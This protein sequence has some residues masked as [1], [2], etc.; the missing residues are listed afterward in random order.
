MTG[1]LLEKERIAKLPGVVWDNRVEQYR[2]PARFYREL[3]LELKNIGFGNLK[4]FP[5]YILKDEWLEIP[6]RS[7]QEMALR[8]WTLADHKGVI[9]LPT[10]AGKT[11]VAIAAIKE[12]K[13]A[14][15]CL[16]PTRV[17][18]YQWFDSIKRFYKGP[19]GIIGDG[20]YEIH[21]ITVCTYESA[22][23]YISRFGNKFSL[24]VVDETHHF[25]SGL[26]DEILEMSVAPFRIGLTATVPEDSEHIKKLSDIIGPIV[27]NLSIND[28]SGKYLAEYE[29][30]QFFLDL[31]ERERMAYRQEISIFRDYM[32]KNNKLLISGGWSNLM[33]IAYKTEE[34]IR[35]FSSLRRATQIVG[36]TEAKLKSL[37]RLLSYHKQDK[38]LIFTADKASTYIISKLFLI[39][40][41]TSE[42]NKTERD[43]YFSAFIEGKLNCI[44]SCRVLNEGIDVPEANVAIILG[45]KLGYREHVQRIGR[46]LRP[47][48]RK[49][50]IIYELISKG[51][52]EVR[53][54]S[55]RSKNFDSKVAVSI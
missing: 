31:N 34:G 55:E 29:F 12:L 20:K 37:S 46:I 8:E 6:L 27:F 49:K 39:P 14:S 52:M 7:Y 48:E 11:F 40:P 5:H 10:G 21:P 28:L 54:S 43:K 22:Y 3:F 33:R 35:A 13:R 15:L 26:R 45:G 18:L 23:R 44:V 42:I 2:A 41:I 38:I 50:A 19:V 1:S 4:S 36:L 24:M 51:T 16:V 25:G 30:F 9:T 47:K 17:L 53:K 32:K